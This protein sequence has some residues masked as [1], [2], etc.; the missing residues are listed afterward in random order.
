MIH[1]GRFGVVAY[2]AVLCDGCLGV[3]WGSFARGGWREA[4]AKARRW[5]FAVRRIGRVR[6]RLGEPMVRTVT[7]HYCQDC[8]RGKR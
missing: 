6:A 4:E 1:A 7:R 3:C 8:R 5:G 2:S